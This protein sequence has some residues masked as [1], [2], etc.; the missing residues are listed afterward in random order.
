MAQLIV[1]VHELVQNYIDT[2]DDRSLAIEISDELLQ[3]T[4]AVIKKHTLP[5]EKAFKYHLSQPARMLS[6]TMVHWH[7]IMLRRMRKKTNASRPWT[8]CFTWNLPQE[9]FECLKC[10]MLCEE[11][12]GTVV[13]NT[14]C[15]AELQTTHHDN[16]HHL[17]TSLANKI[18]RAHV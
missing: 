2:A 5:G 4:R 12:G 10:C 13:K 11:N 15:V 14:R 3:L 9:M 1:S 16:F 17:F 7:K 18:G 8:V 6:R